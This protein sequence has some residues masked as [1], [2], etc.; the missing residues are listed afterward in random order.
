MKTKIT[1]YSLGWT[2]CDKPASGQPLAVIQRREKHINRTRNFL[3]IMPPG[4]VNCSPKGWGGGVYRSEGANMKAIMAIT[5]IVL[6]P[7]SALALDCRKVET[8]NKIEIVCEG[9][10]PAAK[11]DG[12]FDFK[13]PGKDESEN[14]EIMGQLKKDLNVLIKSNS[15]PE[16]IRALLGNTRVISRATSNKCAEDRL[17]TTEAYEKC[18][19]FMKQVYQAEAEI[20]IKSADF[21]AKNNMKSL[22]KETYQDMIRIFKGDEYGSFI[23]QA[24]SGLEALKEK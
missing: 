21:F 1:G 24:E 4:R 7:L 9:E 11:A 19:H 8:D 2:V 3:T 15:G 6:F 10:S 18:L 17:Y 23:R 20:M 22:A 14:L 5:L 12:T 16:S 13:K